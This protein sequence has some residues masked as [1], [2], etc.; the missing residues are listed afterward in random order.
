MVGGGA[1]CSAHCSAHYR[2][3]C[4]QRMEDASSGAACWWREGGGSDMALGCGGQQPRQQGILP[5]QQGILKPGQGNA[6]LGWWAAGAGG[7][8]S[9]RKV[10]S[11]HSGSCS[12]IHPGERFPSSF[13][14][15]FLSKI[16]KEYWKSRT[17]GEIGWLKKNRVG[18]AIHFSNFIYDI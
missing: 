16:P 14:T 2:G 3:G 13:P 9:W 15:L 11:R 1:R 8:T 12:I 4:N 17:L 5:R 7:G 10:L 6:L 18:Y